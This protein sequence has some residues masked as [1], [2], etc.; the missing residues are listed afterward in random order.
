MKA[1]SVIFIALVVPLAALSAYLLSGSY[2]VAA[3]VPHWKATVWF[4]ELVR[5]RSIATHSK[6]VDLPPLENPN[7]FEKGFSH[8]HALCRLCHDAPGYQRGEFA[9]GLNPSPPKLT[10][11]NT[12]GR[13]DEEL[14]WIIKNGIKMTGM[15]SFSSTHSTEEMAAIVAFLRRLPALKPDEYRS[16]I[17][18]AGM[19]E[20]E[21]HHH[22]R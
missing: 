7:L 18:V 2:N 15:P 16:M 19:P 13:T 4:L 8:Y 10:S 1:F 6:R 11:E 17:K 14:Y 12:Q 20:E 3:N 21:I 9:R 22:H 5:E